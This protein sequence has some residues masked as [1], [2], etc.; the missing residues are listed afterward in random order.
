MS[1]ETI[2]AKLSKVRKTQ[3]GYMACCPV[4]NDK[5]PSMTITETDDGKVLAHCFSCGAK[6]SDVVEAL[7]LPQGELFSGEF[8]GT[9]DAKFKLRKTELEDNMVIT[10]YEQE[11]RDGKYLTHAD[12]K[13]YR[14]AKSRI[15]QL[16]S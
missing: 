7:G 14:L 10:L 5:N 9:Y 6:G 15:E 3:R 12:Y 8:T 13:R 11:K 4:H 1:L 2:L 16:A